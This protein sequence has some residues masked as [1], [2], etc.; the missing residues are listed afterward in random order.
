MADHQ[1][2]LTTVEHTATS[3]ELIGLPSHTARA[4]DVTELTSSKFTVLLS[5]HPLWLHTICVSDLQ[6]LATASTAVPTTLGSVS[7]STSPTLLQKQ[8]PLPHC[9]TAAQHV[10]LAPSVHEVILRRELRHTLS[11]NA[12]Q[13]RERSE[14]LTRRGWYRPGQACA[15]L[16]KCCRHLLNSWGVLRGVACFVIGRQA[17]DKHTSNIPASRHVHTRPCAQCNLAVLGTTTKL[18]NLCQLFLWNHPK[19]G[20]GNLVAG[21]SQLGCRTQPRVFSYNETAPGEDPDWRCNVADPTCS[22]THAF[23]TR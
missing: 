21:V 8:P 16:A 3:R 1:P 5:D 19:L 11:L 6:R 23:I 4:L 13:T 18:Q 12:C 17:L 22:C 9:S 14:Q 2:Q 10:S 7:S 15:C 20:S